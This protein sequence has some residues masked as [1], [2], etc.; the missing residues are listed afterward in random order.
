MPELIPWE[1]FDDNYVSKFCKGFGALVK[2]FSI[3]LGV[4]INKTR[5]WLT[6]ECL[7]K[8]I[9]ENHYLRFFIGLEGFH[10]SVPFD[11]S[12]MVYFWKR[13]SESVPNEC[14]ALLDDL[15]RLLS[16][17]LEEAATGY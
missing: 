16:P 2:P 14:N 3:P 13:L 17:R 6:D 5:L 7:A 15:S 10:H 11:P 8:H 9:K 1:Q 4:L 12:M